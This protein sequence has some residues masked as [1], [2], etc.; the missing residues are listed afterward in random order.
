MR[1]TELVRA[2]WEELSRLSE[3]DSEERSLLRDLVTA[4]LGGSELGTLALARLESHPGEDSE[5]VARVVLTEAVESDAAFAAELR[6]VLVRVLGTRALG[7][8]SSEPPPPSHTPV[9]PPPSHTPVPP[10]PSH[11]PATPPPPS[12]APAPVPPPGAASPPQQHY[13]AF[14]A[15]TTPA[16]V[17]PQVLVGPVKRPS[18]WLVFWLGLPQ[19]FMLLTIALATPGFEGEGYV[20]VIFNL[21]SAAVGVVLGVVGLGRRPVQG[22]PLTG[23][24]VG[25]LLDVL[26]ALFWL[27]VLTGD[28]DLNDAVDGIISVRY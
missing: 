24:A 8:L 17:L 26:V 5:S 19:S 23:L 20:L 13:Q 6:E 7:S 12:H 4:R 25:F 28:V 15:Y 11:A 22:L 14:P 10:P 3:E 18:A 27:A 21:F 16:Y 1:E 2:V 9:P